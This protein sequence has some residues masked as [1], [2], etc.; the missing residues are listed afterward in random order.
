MIGAVCTGMGF[1]GPHS[2][3]FS[4]INNTVMTL[5]QMAFGE[6]YLEE[7]LNSNLQLAPVFFYIFTIIFYFV[8]MRF[9]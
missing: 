8:V 2:A 5:F 7:M 1:F 6:P 4:S 9:F 3:R